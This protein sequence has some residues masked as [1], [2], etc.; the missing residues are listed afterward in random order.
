MVQ[1]EADI[2]IAIHSKSRKTLIKSYFMKKILMIFCLGIPLIGLCQSANNANYYA[3][4]AAT[5]TMADKFTCQS[6]NGT[7]VTS[8]QERATQK[9][10]DFYDFLAIISN[11]AYEK[12]M[13]EDAGTQARQLFYNADCTVDGKGIKKFID[14]CFSLKNR[15][16]WQ[17][18]NI[19]VVEDMKPKAN[20]L[21]DQYYEGKLSFNLVS[22]KD[23][24][25]V[26]N[27]Y[28][29]LTKSGK[30]FGASK[31]DVWTAYICDIR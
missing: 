20:V 26:K 10:Q 7:Q 3:P 1:R 24:T 14:S 25:I 16:Q 4:S 5:A 12:H 2:S 30:Q 13:R 23:T 11:P 17:A 8:F 29:M 9:L 22:G 19:K 6:L 21:D 31:K 15:L 28:I 18:V 27:A